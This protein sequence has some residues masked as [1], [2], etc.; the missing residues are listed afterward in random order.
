MC[1][2][3]WGMGHQEN[4]TPTRYLAERETYCPSLCVHAHDVKKKKATRVLFCCV[5]LY[6][7]TY[8]V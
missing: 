8:M 6:C 7:V 5:L 1:V 3:V 2:Y 4:M